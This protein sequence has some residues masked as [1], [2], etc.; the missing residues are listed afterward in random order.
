MIG[1]RRKQKLASSNFY[2]GF[3]EILENDGNQTMT[4]RLRFFGSINLKVYQF[5]FTVL[6]VSPKVAGR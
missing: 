5:I 4:K 2:I 6:R 1:T 3:P